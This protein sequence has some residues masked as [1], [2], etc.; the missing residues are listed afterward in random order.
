MKKKLKPLTRSWIMMSALVNAD[1]KLRDQGTFLGFLWTLLHPLIYFIVLYNL[2]VKWMGPQINNFALYLIIG[3]VHWNFFSAAT[4]ASITC[5]FR[6]ENYVKSIN[7]PKSILVISSALSSLYIHLLELVVLMV[8]WLLVK[9]S[10]TPKAVLIIPIVIL[11]LYLVISLSFILTTIGVYLLDIARIWGILMNVGLFLTPIFYSMD[12]L[13]PGRQKIILLNP[14]THIIKAS[15]DI[16][17]DGQYPA[18]PGLI[19][20]FALSSVLLITGIV[21]FR[22]SEGLFVERL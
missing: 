12:M 17:I 4:T 13:S 8:F 9:G 19:Y 14:M 3:F 22:R 15:R 20:V 5:V 7:F 16:L 2:F 11:T 18:M 1:F 10:V 21:I 6:H